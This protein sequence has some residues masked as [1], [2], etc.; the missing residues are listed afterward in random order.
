MAGEAA[1]ACASPDE[2]P[3]VA[4]AASA[5]GGASTARA[6]H[7]NFERL[8]GLHGDADRLSAAAA[9]L[10]FWAHIAHTGV[11][12][13]TRLGNVLWVDATLVVQVGAAKAAQSWMAH[14]TT[15]LC[16]SSRRL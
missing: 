11:V 6:P 16:C 3:E 8:A 10:P 2:A 14:A 13:D 12:V 1:A 4:Y 5:T 15:S 7:V 9:R